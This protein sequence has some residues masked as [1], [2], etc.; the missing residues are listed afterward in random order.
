MNN[1]Q[2]AE[3]RYQGF[4]KESI[5]VLPAGCCLVVIQPHFLKE[6]LVQNTY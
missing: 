1:I 4:R 5:M 6:S 3:A 2:A